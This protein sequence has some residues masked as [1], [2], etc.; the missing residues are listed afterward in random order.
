MFWC[1]ADYREHTI[2]I[3]PQ[4]CCVC[5]LNRENVVEITISSDCRPSLDFDILHVKDSFII[6]LTGF[7]YGY[8]VIDNC[9]LDK[10]GLK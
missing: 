7:Q 10:N 3:P 5:G 6:D 9:V 2:W 4:L 8:N 1:L